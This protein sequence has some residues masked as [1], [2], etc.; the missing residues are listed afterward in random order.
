MNDLIFNSRKA[1]KEGKTMSEAISFAV[2]QDLKTNSQ[3]QT[4][5]ALE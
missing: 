1:M 4:K 3:Y 5:V 2:N